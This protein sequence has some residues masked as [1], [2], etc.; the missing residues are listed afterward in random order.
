MTKQDLI[1]KLA[2]ELNLS[3]NQAGE[4]LNMILDEISKSLKKGQNV[5]LTGFGTFSVTKRKSRIGIN[6]R[7]G[8]RIQIS[9]TKTPKFK[10][11]KSLKD[12]VKKG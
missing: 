7:T 11:G 12:S 10:A 3:K 9:A 5:V 2:K 8:E 4:C 1:E 6:P